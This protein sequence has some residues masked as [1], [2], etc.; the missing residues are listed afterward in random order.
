MKTITSVALLTTIVSLSF[1]PIASATTSP[2]TTTRGTIKKEI[3]D[4]RT[5]GKAQTQIKRTEIKGIAS[6][7]RAEIKE[8]LAG[9]QKTRLM[10]NLSTIDKRFDA[11]MKRLSGIATRIDSR[12][13]KLTAE[14]VNESTATANM[15]I[16]RTKIATASTTINALPT[17]LA[18]IVGTEERKAALTD[19]KKLIAEA[20][21]A[22]AIAQKAL[23]VAVSSIKPGKNRPATTTPVTATTTA[24]TVQ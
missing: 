13:A 15:V 2:A 14:G 9:Q 19:S 6:T 23:S 3:M 1:A 8:V 20:R 22:V 21:T 17:R 10:K 4:L 16:A 18:N 12:I 7:T 5:T 24:T 11:A